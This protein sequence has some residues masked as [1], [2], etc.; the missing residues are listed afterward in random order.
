MENNMNEFIAE[1]E[2]IDGDV[3]TVSVDTNGTICEFHIYHTSGCFPMDNADE[4]E[5]LGKWLIDQAKY[6]RSE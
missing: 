5:R 4:V 2:D 3:M 1:F 6:M